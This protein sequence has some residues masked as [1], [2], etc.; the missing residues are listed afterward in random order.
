MKAIRSIRE[1]GRSAQ[2]D[3]SAMDGQTIVFEKPETAHAPGRKG[4][5]VF[6]PVEVR[7]DRFGLEILAM[8]ARL[9]LLTILVVGVAFAGIATGVVRAYIDMAPESDIKAISV[10]SQG[11][12]IYDANG[13]L[14]TTYSGTED[15]IYGNRDI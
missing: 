14:I 12:K 9:L 15:R 11:S 8:T 5:S 4:A 3:A 6:S 13:D 10:Q 2:D 7:H 1:Q